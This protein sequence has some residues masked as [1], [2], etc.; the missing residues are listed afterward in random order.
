MWVSSLIDFKILMA[1]QVLD[2]FGA[3]VLIISNDVLFSSGFNIYVDFD[4]MLTIKNILKVIDSDYNFFTL[5]VINLPFL[6][7]MD[8][9][10]VKF[11]FGR[12]LIS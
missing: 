4:F 9:S 12:Y 1:F 7:L 3:S 11:L 6:S 10:W 2:Y 8:F 5:D